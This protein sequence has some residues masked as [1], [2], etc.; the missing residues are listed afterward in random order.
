M[1]RLFDSRSL[2]PNH[3][4]VP[5]GKLDYER[6]Y[7]TASRPTSKKTH[8]HKFLATDPDKEEVMRMILLA[9]ALGTI[10][11]PTVRRALI[12]AFVVREKQEIL[13]RI[14]HFQKTSIPGHA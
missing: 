13:D 11:Q 12:H 6:L 7:P 1:P 3:P 4:I 8:V 9:T 5:F 10:R 2:F 14:S